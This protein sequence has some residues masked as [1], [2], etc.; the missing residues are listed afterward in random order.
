MQQEGVEKER[1]QQIAC[2]TTDGVE[3]Q[4]DNSEQK[5]ATRHKLD[6]RNLVSMMYLNYCC[7]TQ[8]HHGP[9][10]ETQIK[11]RANIDIYF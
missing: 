8:T 6:S 2:L 10:F 11:P 3:S 5:G 4:E 7:Q 1:K 9:N